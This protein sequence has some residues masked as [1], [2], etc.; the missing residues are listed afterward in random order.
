MKPRIGKGL[1]AIGVAGCA[2][3]A[4]A[5]DTRAPLMQTP[6]SPARVPDGAV[7]AAPA[8]SGGGAS[9]LQLPAVQTQPVQPQPAQTPSP[10]WRTGANASAPASQA[11][12]T[13]ALPIEERV[14]RL[15][16]ALLKAN[17]RI[18]ELETRM[19]THKHEFS[20]QYVGMMVVKLNGRDV[21]VAWGPRWEKATTDPALP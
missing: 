7:R 12:M 1:V 10:Q 18:V 19:R 20:R 6:Q 17:A 9:P 11:A 13:A 4:L 14:A 3:A 8:P 16:A 2:F 5:Q 21:P 15:E